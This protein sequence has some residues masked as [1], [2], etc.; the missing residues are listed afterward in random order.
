LQKPSLPQVDGA[1]CVHSLSGSVPLVMLRQR[2][3]AWPVFPIEHAMHGAVQ[4]DSQ[5]TPSTQLFDE[6]WP[7]VAHGEPS[8]SVVPQTLPLQVYPV[9]QSELLAQLVLHAVGLQAYGSHGTVETVWQVPEPL[10][11][12]AGV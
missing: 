12:R 9:A 10:Q 4:A 11:V 7:L 6:H 8:G 3:F 2:P 1:L 5:Q